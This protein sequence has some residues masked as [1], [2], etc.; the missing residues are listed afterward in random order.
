VL[1]FRALGWESLG[2]KADEGTTDKPAFTIFPQFY[3]YFRFAKTPARPDMSED[4]VAFMER[5]SSRFG[6]APVWMRM[7]LVY[8]L[9]GRPDDAV[10]AAQTLSRLH[11]HDYPE[12][13]AVWQ[14]MA[15]AEPRKYAEVFAR[16]EKPMHETRKR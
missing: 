15:Q 4:E 1:G 5:V 3:D 16:M 10:R 9:N 11:P 7:S 2:L 12:A 14:G 8:A 6:Y 13:Y